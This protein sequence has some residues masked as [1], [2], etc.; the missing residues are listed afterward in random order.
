[1][2]LPVN[3]V[4]H[5]NCDRFVSL[6]PF[7]SCFLFYKMY[8][9]DETQS[10]DMHYAVYLPV[11][12]LPMAIIEVDCELC[13]CDLRPVCCYPFFIIFPNN[14]LLLLIQFRR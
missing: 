6:Y 14:M 5:H 13:G 1:M 4:Y 2:L 10:C 11:C 3:F 8:V 12:A 9:I 7:V